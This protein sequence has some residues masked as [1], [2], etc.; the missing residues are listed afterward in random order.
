M[1]RITQDDRL[2]ANSPGDGLPTSPGNRVSAIPSVEILATSPGLVPMG[3]N[4]AKDDLADVVSWQVAMKR[5]IRS[6]AQLR[7]ALDLPAANSPDGES[8]FPTFV[9]LEF[10]RRMRHRDP[11]D[12][13]L[14]QV[15]P[16]SAEDDLDRPGFSSDP[17]GDMQALVAGGLLHKYGGRA[18]VVT[19]GACGVHCRY[20]FRRQF[21]YSDAGSQND[22]YRPAI[23]YLKK[24]ISVDEVILSGGDPLTLTDAK[25]DALISKIESIPHVQRIRF[26][27]RMPVVIPQRVTD[28]LVDRLRQSRLTAW[29]VIHAN[30]AAEIDYA[31]VAATNKLI[32]AGIPVLNQAVLLR[33]VNDNV[34]TLA[35]LCTRLVDHRISPYYLHQLDRVQGAAHFEVSESTGRDLIDQLTKRLPGYAVP[36]YVV[37]QAGEASKTRLS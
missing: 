7:E 5:A 6:S 24:S 33:G 22:N 2:A 10:L 28:A 4:S 29:F 1:S 8:D 14:M 32:D 35:Q 25:L 30:H 36:T 15:M 12:P 27:S 26:H 37:E 11:N 31:V 17:V 23:E 19:T 13:L 34:E 18:L 20:C 16:I 3:C 9:P 21:P